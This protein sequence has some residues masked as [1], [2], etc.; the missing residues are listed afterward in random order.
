MNFG[1]AV[2]AALLSIIDSFSRPIPGEI[3]YG[4][5]T[6]L[7]Y[8]LPLTIGWLHVGSEPEPNHLRDS[9]E[10][11]NEVALVATKEGDEPVFAESLPGQPQR[12]I[13]KKLHEGPAR[14]DELKTNP[15]YNYS[16]V[17]VWSKI[18]EV[19]YTSARNAT[20]KAQ[21]GSPTIDGRETNMAAEGRNWTAYEVICR[22]KAEGSTFEKVFKTPHHIIL[23]FFV[24][25]VEIQDRSLWATGVWKRV[26]LATALAIGLQW[27]TTGAGMFMYYKM[28]PVGLGCR[29][30]ALLIY[31]IF[32]TVSFLLLLGSST[33]AHLH[34]PRSGSIYPYSRLRSLQGAGAILTRRLGKTMAVVSGVG[35]LLV[36]IAQPL[37]V[38]DNCWCSTRTFD[39]PGG[40]AAF[41]DGDFVREWGILK[42]WISGLVTAFATSILFG[43][44]LY[45][46][47]PRRR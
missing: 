35:I 8:L 39:R 37:G 2:V 25:P 24:P 41:M 11:A 18:A 20:A 38:F 21:K 36:S 5:V 3:G 4:T 34:R 32:G 22:C 10:E 17:F 47:T 15:L 40:Y 7:A 6:T 45:L 28:H 23:P 27:G 33:L 46:G 26:A 31:G 19:I 12:A 44:S 14:R 1:W 29:T 43:F 16:R 42:V 30:T 9:L 13:E